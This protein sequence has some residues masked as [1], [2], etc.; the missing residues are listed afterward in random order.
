LQPDDV[1]LDRVE[2]V[3]AEFA[4]HPA[5]FPTV[6]RHREPIPGTGRRSAVLAPLFEGGTG[7]TR[8]LLTRRSTRLRSHRGEVAFPGGRIDDGEEPVAAAL[9]E[10][11]EEIGLP[12]ERVRIIGQL[13]PLS[14]FTT[15]A[16]ITPYVGVVDDVP[17]LVP[18]EHEVDRVF[19]VSL[20]ELIDP[21]CYRE[22]IWPRE[23]GEYPVYFF[24]VEGETIWGATGRMLHRLLTLRA[25]F[26]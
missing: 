17:E 9:R 4:S 5:R 2:K 14:T 19:D 26:A 1:A 24:E 20:F 6:N 25:S 21:E 13:D 7:D 18:S 15:N 10:A 11:Y 23:D 3:L 12:P 22:E 16:A 8:V